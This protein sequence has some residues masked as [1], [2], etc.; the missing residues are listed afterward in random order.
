[1]S[2]YKVKLYTSKEFTVEANNP[3]EAEKIAKDRLG[4]DYHIDEVVTEEV[5]KEIKYV[6]MSEFF[7]KWK[8]MLKVFDDTFET[9]VARHEIILNQ[10]VNI[11]LQALGIKTEIPFCPQTIEA[12]NK[13]YKELIADEYIE[14]IVQK[15]QCVCTGGGIYLAE[16]PFKYDDRNFVM[17]VDNEN[18]TEWAVYQN[19]LKYN[20]KYD[21]VEYDE[22]MN[23]T[24]NANDISPDFQT[25]YI[26]ALQL[27]ANR[28]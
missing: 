7:T 3:V 21:S 10:T 19:V 8:E 5:K 2:T 16:V 28:I 27:L 26:R 18:S 4:C 20:G 6:S 14:Y 13:L 12:L 11:E 17:V 15:E 22:L 1:M 9:D 23:F 25:Y 24:G